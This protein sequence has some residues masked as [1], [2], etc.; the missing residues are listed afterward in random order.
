VC[1][2]KEIEIGK[3]MQRYGSNMGEERQMT[4][5]LGNNTDN[6]GIRIHAHEAR[7]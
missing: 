4:A 6:K 3:Y 5:G 7:G 2:N 1:Y